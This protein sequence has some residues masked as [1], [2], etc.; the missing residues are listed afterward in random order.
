M[1]YR[2]RSESP[3]WYLPVGGPSDVTLIYHH[4]VFVSLIDIEGV[5]NIGHLLELQ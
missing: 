2:R 5:I 3:R 1:R 4:Q